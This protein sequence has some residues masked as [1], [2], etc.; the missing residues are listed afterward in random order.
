M[1]REEYARLQAVFEEA[2]GREGD[3]RGAYLD[4]AC[5]GDETLRRRVEQLLAQDADEKGPDLERRG[6]LGTDLFDAVRAESE[7]L[8]GPVPK[9]GRYRI[10]RK[11]ADGGMG[12]V[13]LAEQD[14]PRRQV[15]LKVIRAG[16]ITEELRRRFEVE[17]ELLGRLQ[18]PGIAQ[19]YEAGE[20]EIDGGSLPYFAMEYIDG[21]ELR[22]YAADHELGIAARLELLAALCD[23]VSHAHQKG[24][25]H[26]DLKP[27]NVLVVEETTLSATAPRGSSLRARP[28]VLDF[29]VSRLAREDTPDAT[30]L[31]QTG[32]VLGTLAYMS[33]EQAGGEQDVDTRSDVYSLGVI[34]F[35]LV[36]GRLPRDFADVRL[37]RALRTIQERAAPR[38]DSVDRRFR[39][40]LAIII[41]KALELEPERRYASAAAL[42]EDLR[43][44]LA[45][46]PINAR[47]PT[48]GYQLSRFVRRNRLLA[49]GMLVAISG[50][51]LAL[52]LAVRA[53]GNEATQR[54]VAEQRTEDAR[55]TAYAAQ[56]QAANTLLIGEGAA[57]ARLQLSSCDPELRGWEWE[58]LA[59][60]AEDDLATVPMTVP[61]KPYA[62]PTPGEDHVLLPVDDETLRL[63]DLASAS[64]HD[65]TLPD[66][67]LR[68]THA[69]A[70][71]PGHASALIGREDGQLVLVDL[72]GDRPPR[73]VWTGEHLISWL[74]V[75]PDQRHLAVVLRRLSPPESTETV[76]YL[77]DLDTFEV[78]ARREALPRIYDLA[79][80]PA[81]GAL[82]AS[83][84]SGEV[85][86]LDAITLES[87]RAHRVH[88]GG[89]VAIAYS[90]SGEKLA[91]AG[92]DRAVRVWDP[93]TGRVQH[94]LGP[95]Q[96]MAEALAFTPDGKT[97]LTGHA[98]A[99]V[100]FWDLE[101]GTCTRL[102][103]QGRTAEPAD[104]AI[105]QILIRG[106]R[107]FAGG[108]D[109]VHV[110]SLHE[111]PPDL[112]HHAPG[113]HSYAYGIDFDPSGSRLASAGWDGY[114]RIWDVATRRAI[115]ELACPENAQWAKYLGEGRGLLTSAQTGYT[116]HV[117]QRW[118]A[119]TLR[120][121]PSL[122][123]G[124]RR[125]TGL[126]VPASDA[127]LLG[128][129]VIDRTDWDFSPVRHELWNLDPDTL[130][131]QGKR[132]VS[133]EIWAMALS[134]DGTRFA[135]G[136]T[137]GEL[138]LGDAR[139]LEPRRTWRAHEG[140]IE[141]LAFSPDGSRLASG[142]E[143]EEIRIWKVPG[144]EEVLRFGVPGA[145]DLLAL[146]FSP[147]GRRIFSGSRR[148][149]I[150][151]WDA[152]SGLELLRLH[153]HQDYVHDLQLSPDGR[154]LA[155]ASGDG[156]VRLWDARPLR[157]RDGSRH[158]VRAAEEEVRAKVER[159]LAEL[160][161]REEVMAA[162]A[163]DPDWSE[164]ER[165]AA[166]NVAQ[167]AWRS[168]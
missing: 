114:V 41:G 85:Y 132:E 105:R 168:D 55:H 89:V 118:S 146:A 107:V 87:V 1:K 103:S 81:G 76:L 30:K 19:I 57:A 29:G 70:L 45:D 108:L 62:P 112:L 83:M 34:G 163:A 60:N 67:I 44:Y 109:G 18:H 142:G 97:L 162:I 52:V 53:Q 50:L 148:V 15:A 84:G 14:H 56:I 77:L 165:S 122:E 124:S 26:R 65:I 116:A 63:F 54:R 43:R 37:L 136:M 31:T 160:T 7:T 33:P 25:V 101:R 91:S 128:T 123:Y 134:S 94:T 158:R 21:V 126:F 141:A 139:S 22:R 82:A 40:D 150:G 111:P 117:L 144:G 86:L 11:I 64:G 90:P 80:P 147:D 35:E 157:E 92:F 36:S 9:I 3:V 74:E 98:D 130:E 88:D 149:S 12:T 143:G 47:P 28:V 106:E 119:N 10:E 46:Q 167:R 133:A 79:F 73:T 166:E 127:F 151:I 145:R 4:R 104:S 154:I 95:G 23:A 99:R 51:L 102:T 48:I 59:R 135:Y 115:T 138:V 96:Y 16:V 24:I 93:G 20:A 58:Y 100:R 32:H 39:G 164:L 153:G 110:R 155:S 120:R 140:A 38:L 137:N 72:K 113:E 125:P 152:R 121:G 17:T 13:Y 129:T 161:T 5:E 69:V 42:A 156:T 75:S 71:L 61:P 159:W 49:G 6:A 131:A 27:G 8:A 78:L 66:P 2:V 68:D